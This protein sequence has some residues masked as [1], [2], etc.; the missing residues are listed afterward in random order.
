[1]LI[2]IDSL[3]YNKKNGNGRERKDNGSETGKEEGFREKQEEEAH[4]RGTAGDQRCE[5]GQE[6]VCGSSKKIPRK[7]YYL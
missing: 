3:T 4:D 6:Q 7:F 5:A 2:E 1:M